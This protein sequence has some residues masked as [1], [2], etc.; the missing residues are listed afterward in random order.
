[1]KA[2]FLFQPNLAGRTIVL[3][4]IV[5]SLFTM[6][7]C[8]SH[9][10]TRSSKLEPTELK[11][12]AYYMVPL[13]ATIRENLVWTDSLG[14][15]RILSE[16]SPDAVVTS[17]TSVS[18]KITGEL[19]TGQKLSA[20]QATTITQSLSELG[21]RTV[22]VSILR[23]ALYRLEEFNVN[24][25]GRMMDTAT[26]KLFLEILKSAQT[27]ANAEQE[28]EKAKTAEK[29]LEKEKEVTKQ[30]MPKGGASEK[31]TIASQW[32][33]KG[34]NLLLSDNIDGAI[35]AF[36]EAEKIYPTYHNVYELQKVLTENKKKLANS[37]SAEAKAVLDMIVDQ[38]SWGMDEETKSKLEAKSK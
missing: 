34:F 23:D 5:F 10:M 37:K 15:F 16:V 38:Y 19:A 4:V 11:P 9:R 25:N 22:A 31:Y 30:L 13:D 21:K 28:G 14:R 27:I 12:N 17:V 24:S 26:Y 8:S 33:E 2:Q 18:G 1:M 32:E 36:K 29:E 6:F 7:S 35:E 3:V 20:E